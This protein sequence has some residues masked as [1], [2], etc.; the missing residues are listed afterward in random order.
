M[1]IRV[2]GNPAPQGSKTAVVRGGKA[3]MFESS[4]RLPEWRETVM[5]TARMSVLDERPLDPNTPVKATMYFLLEPPRKLERER[6]TTKPDLDKLVR[7]VN[8]ALVDAGVIQDDSLIVNL[9]AY[10]HYADSDEPAGV[11]ITLENI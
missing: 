6:P 5:L 4:K 3:I 9:H 10:K 2:F 11:S 8:D 7:A 1:H